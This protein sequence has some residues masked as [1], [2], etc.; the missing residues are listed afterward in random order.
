[1]ANGIWGTLAVGLFATGKGEGAFVDGHIIDITK[2]Q[3][4]VGNGQ[5]VYLKVW[6][7][8]ITYADVIK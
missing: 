3:I 1:M 8:I 5:S 6:D 7:K 4:A 2:L